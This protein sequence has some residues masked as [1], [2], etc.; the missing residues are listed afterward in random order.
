MNKPIN[1]TSKPRR[2]WIGTLVGSVV[3][4]A[5]VLLLLVGIGYAKARQ[6]TAAMA[7]P[8]P[9][10][11]PVAVTLAKAE[12]TTFRRSSVVVGTVLASESI[13]LQTELTGLVTEVL[14]RPGDTV[15]KGDLL[16]QLDDRT[17]RAQL[18]S[19]EASREL[20]RTEMARKERLARANA[21]SVSDFDV[22]SA[23]LI[24]AGAMVDE[25]KVMIDRKQ[26]KAPFDA[27]VG[28][29]DLH[30]GQYLVEGSRITTLEG[31]ANYFYV[32]FSM[33][34]HVA[35]AIKIG[36]RVDV[37][38]DNESGI[39]SAEIIA[40]DAAADAISRSV[41]ARAILPDPPSMLQ[42]NDSVRVTIYY[43]DSIAASVIPATAVRRSPTGTVVYVAS[44]V[45]GVMRAVSR[46]VVV[47][48]GSGATTRILDGVASGESV[49]AD[50]SF[51][52]YDGTMVADASAAIASPSDMPKSAEGAQR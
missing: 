43:G 5:S 9:P 37:Q 12:P 41:M 38:V 30:V 7:S 26:L 22:A 47:A 51:K 15:K 34:A 20:A 6:I 35:D 19:A 31:I 45:D 17:E 18:K 8:P 27:H 39:A 1:L 24:R 33:P 2:T 13:L 42:P 21:G 44:E 11:I 16:I 14:I 29:F 49:V 36:D 28:M 3:V 23:E 32:D 50:G 46:D 4:I 52:V 25:L 40:I 10:E 48:G